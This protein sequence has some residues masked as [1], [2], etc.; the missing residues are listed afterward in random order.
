MCKRK[1]LQ[2]SWSSAQ[3]KDKHSWP[4]S[5][6]RKARRKSGQSLRKRTK[7][8]KTKTVKKKAMKARATISRMP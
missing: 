5:L 8:W 2:N 1:D 6:K 3:F 4:V 7:E